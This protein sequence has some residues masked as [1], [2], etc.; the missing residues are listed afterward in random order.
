MNLMHLGFVLRWTAIGL[1]IGHL[2]RRASPWLIGLE[3]RRLPFRWPWPELLG[4]VLFTAAAV[5]AGFSGSEPAVRFVFV[6]LLLALVVTD[7]QRKVLPDVLTLGGTL[8]GLALAAWRPAPLES[9]LVQWLS[10]RYVHVGAGA[11]GW[12]RGLVLAMLGAAVGFLLL[13][14]FRRLLAALTGVDGLGGGDPKLL[15]MIGAF[16]GPHAVLVALLPACAIGAAIGVIERLRTGL[17]HAAFGPALAAGGVA[18]MLAGELLVDLLWRLSMRLVALPV[19]AL[20]A[21]YTVLA[22]LLVF[23]IL[24]LR[25]RAAAY[26]EILDQDYQALESELASAPDSESPPP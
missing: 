25:R 23:V 9:F 22:T 14:G 4:A 3:D 8:V 24:R 12:I 20:V 7:I 5:P 13:E 10:L 21:F 11:P 15:A 17:P 16:L 6:G 19:G 18:V 1:V 2:A 26:N